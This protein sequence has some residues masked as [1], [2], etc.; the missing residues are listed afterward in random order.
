MNNVDKDDGGVDDGD[1]NNDADLNYVDS[2]PKVCCLIFQFVVIDG[3]TGKYER[4]NQW[5]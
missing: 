4:E 5:A 2:T 1:E 3:S